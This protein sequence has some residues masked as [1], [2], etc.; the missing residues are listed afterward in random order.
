MSLIGRLYGNA[1]IAA[2]L[3]SQR[4]VPFWP[5]P[6][7]EALRDQRL[8]QQVHYAAQHVP[9]YRDLFARE[10][11]DPADIRV[12]ADLERLPLIDREQLRAEP[13]R[14]VADDA[15]ARGALSFTTSGSTATPTRILH[16]RRS[17]LQNMAFGERERQPI[18]AQCGSSF[19]PKEIYVGS[20]DSTFRKVIAFYQENTLLPV[21]PRRRWI[22][23][24]DPIERIVELV[25]AE[26]PDVIVGYGGWH[27]LFFKTVY[28]LQLEL[29]RPKLIVYMA[30]ALPAGARELIEQ[31]FGIAVMSRYSAAEAFKIG[32]YCERRTGFHVH[33]DLCHVRIVDDAG[34]SVPAGERGRIVLSNLV[35]RGTVLLNYPIGDLGRMSST[36]CG[37]GRNFAVLAEVEGRVEDI[38]TLAD[39][40]HLHP[41]AIFHVFKDDRDVLQYQL[42]QHEFRRFTLTL[43]TVD[44][45][46]YQR[47]LA[48]AL[49]KLHALLGEVQITTGRSAQVVYASQRK[50]R[51]VASFRPA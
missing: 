27:E 17:L 43:A 2:A 45:A 39:G 12:A 22:S 4:R 18:I 41:R 15:I 11:I 40:R 49:P 26:R 8:R 30:E 48:R 21:Q 20:E 31:H 6:R 51:A 16:D 37:C 5:R 44:D 23:V 36:E 47:A 24:L 13:L 1:I 33:E 46:A 3:R 7:I 25:N 34:G 38:L 35:N 29:H 14:F 42:T 32:Y 50:F 9:Y 28:S 19:R 10:R